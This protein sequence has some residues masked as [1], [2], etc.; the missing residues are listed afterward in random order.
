MHACYRRL[1]YKTV[2]YEDGLFTQSNLDLPKSP[3]NALISRVQDYIHFL[4]YFIIWSWEDKFE[5]GAISILI[6][7][8]TEKGLWN[9]L[10]LMYFLII[11]LFPQCRLP[12]FSWL[13]SVRRRR[14]LCPTLSPTPRSYYMTM[15]IA[16][17]NNFRTTSLM[18]WTWL[19]INRKRT[20]PNL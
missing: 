4:I 1:V 14:G 16:K 17:L 18:H 12:E 7:S 5:I 10:N 2:K 3:I 11:L 13:V 6:L 20:G 9:N 19:P 15:Q 8:A